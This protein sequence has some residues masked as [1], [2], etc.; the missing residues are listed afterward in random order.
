[1][2]EKKKKR[3]IKAATA[4]SHG[5][6]KAKAE[7]AGKTTREFAEEKAHAPGKLGKQAR[8]AE[9]LMGAAKHHSKHRDRYAAKTVKRA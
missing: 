9:A 2:A 5:Q 6:F 7:K 3:W 1:M 8:L 4:N